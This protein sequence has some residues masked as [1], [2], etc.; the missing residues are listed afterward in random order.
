M[1]AALT[2]PATTISACHGLALAVLASLLFSAAI[3]LANGW[4]A[5]WDLAV[6]APSGPRIYPW[7]LAEPGFWSHATAWA[8][9]LLHQLTLWGG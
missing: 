9:Y 2:Q 6:R 3:W 7:Q 1:P 5:G 4:L 8:G